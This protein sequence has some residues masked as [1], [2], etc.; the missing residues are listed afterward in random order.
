MF[1]GIAFV[2]RKRLQ[3]IEAQEAARQRQLAYA[4]SLMDQFVSRQ[5]A[6]VRRIV[7]DQ[8]II[9]GESGQNRSATPILQVIASVD[10]LREIVQ[11]VYQLFESNS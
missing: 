10:P 6:A 7:P 1:F 5:V 8:P 4:H 2:L 9:S 3:Y 11:S